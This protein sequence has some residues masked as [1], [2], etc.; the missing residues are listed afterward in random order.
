MLVHVHVPALLDLTCTYI[1]SFSPSLSLSL[2]PLSP[3][4]S[5]SIR[6]TVNHFDESPLDEL[7]LDMSPL[8]QSDSDSDEFDVKVPHSK[9]SPFSQKKDYFFGIGKVRTYVYISLS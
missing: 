3:P 8:S 4:P 1:P 9:P 7:P 2:L 5:P 6:V